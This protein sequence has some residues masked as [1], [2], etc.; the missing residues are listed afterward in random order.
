MQ[1]GE[2]D[3]AVA[4][5]SAFGGQRLLHLHDHLGLREDLV[6]SVDDARADRLVVGVV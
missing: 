3:L 6:G 1:I 5:L 4:Q 2:Q